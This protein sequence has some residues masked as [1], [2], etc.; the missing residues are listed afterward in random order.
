MRGRKIWFK[1]FADSAFF[2][3]NSR[4]LTTSE[5]WKAEVFESLDHWLFK[6]KVKLSLH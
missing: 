4:K 3:H 1:N 5:T 6:S 2:V